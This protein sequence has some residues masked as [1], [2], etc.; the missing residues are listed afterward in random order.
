MTAAACVALFTKPATPGRVKTRLIGAL[1]ARQAAA[2]HQ[3]FLDDML[4]RLEAG[5]LPLAIAWAVEAGEPLPPTGHRAFAQEGA[6]LGERL[7]RGL[8]HLADDHPIVIAVGSDHPEMP[9]ERPLEAVAKIE[10]GADLVLGPAADGG[11]YLL[12]VRGDRLDPDLFE[13]VPWSSAETLAATVA[14]ADALGLAVDRLAVGH[15]VD[16]AADLE[17][18]ARHLEADPSAAPRTAALLRSWGR[19]AAT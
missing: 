3:A 13:G 11:Y 2:L 12:A 19:V 16:T 6:T 14:R 8:R 15:D 7:Y 18:L 17:R 1:T 10:A 5:G 9:V 4:A